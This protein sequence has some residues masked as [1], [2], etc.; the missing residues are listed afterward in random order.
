LRQETTRPDVPEAD[1]H[2][3][4]EVVVDADVARPRRMTP[5]HKKAIEYK[6]D[7]R[8]VA[9]YPHSS[10]KAWPKIKA[11]RNQRDR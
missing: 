1:D 4:S 7:R 3:E 10:R 2:D 9:E 6:R 8:F 11:L 5:A